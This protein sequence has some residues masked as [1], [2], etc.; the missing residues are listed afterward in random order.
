MKSGIYT[1]TNLINGKIYVGYSKSINVRLNH[2][3]SEINNNKHG[4]I[5]LQRAID[6]DGIS[7]F[8][9]E[10]LEEYSEDLLVAMEHYWCTILDTHNPERGYN[11]RKTHPY[12]KAASN[13]KETREKISKTLKEYF[14]DNTHPFKGKKHSME[15]VNNM[16]KGAI[17][18]KYINRKLPSKEQVDK[19]L[20]GLKEYRETEQFKED[21][22]KRGDKLK[23]RVITW[24]DKIGAANSR[25]IIQ[26]N[27]NGDKIQEWSSITKAKT[28]LKLSSVGNI[29]QACNG[30]RRIAYGYIWKYKD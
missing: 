11:I 29:S 4:N 19:M 9:F 12:E 14:K 25:T 28:D 20:N 10:I 21:N 7:N 17:G 27:V 5:H 26:Y 22:R 6:I 1:I 18:K 23:G 24:K 16:K 15:S 8:K 30:K 3:K 2:H 13:S